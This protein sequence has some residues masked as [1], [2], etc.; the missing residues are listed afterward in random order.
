MTQ[1]V[2][3]NGSAFV[4]PTSF[5]NVANSGGAVALAAGYSPLF[6]GNLTS[7][8]VGFGTGSSGSTFQVAVY[9]GPAA[10]GG[11]ATLL[12][13][14]SPGT[15]VASTLV[16]VPITP[17]AML[18]SQ[19][20]A[21]VLSMSSLS[22]NVTCDTNASAFLASQ[23]NAAAFPYATPPTPLPARTSGTG[24]P[25]IIWGDGNTGGPVANVVVGQ[26]GIWGWGGGSAN[27]SAN[28]SL[29]VPG[30]FGAWNWNGT[31]AIV[32]KNGTTI[33]PVGGYGK[34]RRRFHRFT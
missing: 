30:A 32:K 11:G 29:S 7:I 20:I 15:I 28:T 26:T 34:G 12:G 16:N 19:T 33:G 24:Y 31:A 1:I 23:Y 9:L 6:N 21:L 17:I 22:A 2:G 27:F 13:V 3:N 5:N 25:F 10:S 4:T 14:S 18:T 8:N